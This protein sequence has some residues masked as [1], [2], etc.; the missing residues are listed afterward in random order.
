MTVNAI[1]SSPPIFNCRSTTTSAMNAT[2]TLQPIGFA[3]DASFQI[4]VK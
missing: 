2:P 4:Q 3:A 1:N